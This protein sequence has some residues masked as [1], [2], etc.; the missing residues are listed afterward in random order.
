MRFRCAECMNS[1][2]HGFLNQTVRRTVKSWLHQQSG[3]LPGFFLLPN[4]SPIKFRSSSHP[5]AFPGNTRG[6]LV[7]YPVTLSALHCSALH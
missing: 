2:S 6:A 4:V 3:S 7:G 1:V 5:N